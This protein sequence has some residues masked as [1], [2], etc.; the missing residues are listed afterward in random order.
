MNELINRVFK[1]WAYTI[2]HC[3]L[4]LRSPQKFPDQDD[5]DENYNYNIDIEFSAVRYIDIPAILNGIEI[6]ELINQ[7]PEKF[8]SYKNEQ[9]YK[10]F[11]IK[12]G[13]KYYY[14]VAANYRIGKNKWVAEDRVSNMSLEYDIIIA[15]S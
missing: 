10:V 5:F 12:S 13:E 2:S 4:I 3:F 6:R 8:Q 1:I 11:E 15:T 9:G 14:I 7:I